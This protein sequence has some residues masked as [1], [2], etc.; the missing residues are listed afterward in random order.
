MLIIRVVAK[1][2]VR[3]GGDTM[4]EMDP[5]VF[6]SQ[7]ESMIAFADAREDY[8]LGAWLSQAHSRIDAMIETPQGL[9]SATE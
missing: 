9:S 4:E 2:A 1:C 8:V 6:A 7:L 5:G 3:V